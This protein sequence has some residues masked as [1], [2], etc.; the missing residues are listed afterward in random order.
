MVL[1]NR[2]YRGTIRK[3]SCARSLM[4]T[5][6][7][8]IRALFGYFVIALMGIVCFIP[9]IFVA[10]LPEKYRFNN[11]VY[12]FFSW[13]FYRIIVWGS[14]L[15]FTVEGK[16]HI[17]E[18]PAILIAN[19]QSA[20]DIPFLGM[21]V[22]CHPHIWLF[23]SRYAKV[24]FFGFVTRRMNVVVD[25]SG[26]RKLTGAITDAARLIKGQK[27]HVLMF[28]EGGRA[29]DGTVH[30]FYYGFVILAKE[31]KRPV[32]PVMMFNLNKAYPPGSFFIHQYP[33]KIVIGEPFRLG[34]DETDEAFLQ[35]VHSWFVQQVEQNKS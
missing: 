35:R 5:V 9:C 24:P 23:L 12:Y 7:L 20:L 28:P 18:E 33:I 15:P 11:K 2:P 1:H 14:F 13:L 31:T 26:L 29:T 25:Y 19:H 30:R 27:R 10:C 21:L 8:V 3:N 16:H 6:F 32:V 4:G 34:D 17:P 22:N